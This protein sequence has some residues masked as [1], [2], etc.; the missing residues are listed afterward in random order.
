MVTVAVKVALFC[1]EGF[2]A[3]VSA[4]VVALGTTN[5]LK[6]GA[7]EGLKLASPL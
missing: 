2:G 6:D 5:W 7:L 4:V 3:I 1:S